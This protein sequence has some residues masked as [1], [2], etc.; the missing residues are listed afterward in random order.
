MY[1]EFDSTVDLY[2]IVQCNVHVCAIAN[3]SILAD[4]TGNHQSNNA[5][6]Q[7]NNCKYHV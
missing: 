4:C 1:R 2:S 5:N 7:H 6:S 3:V